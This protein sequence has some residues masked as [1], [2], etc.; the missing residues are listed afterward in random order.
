MLKPACCAEK[1]MD[2]AVQEQIT[3]WGTLLGNH[4]QQAQPYRSPGIILVLGLFIWFCRSDQSLL[5]AETP[6]LQKFCPCAGYKRRGDDGHL[7][8]RSDGVT[9]SNMV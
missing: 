7:S 3:L 1:P 4:G 5:D 9:Q 2:E 8:D 6:C